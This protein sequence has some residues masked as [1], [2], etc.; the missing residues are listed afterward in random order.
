MC[1]AHWH[2]DPYRLH[3]DKRTVYYLRLLS[4]VDLNRLNS[5]KVKEQTKI[6]LRKALDTIYEH[7]VG[8]YVPAKQFLD[9]MSS[10]DQ[11]LKTDKKN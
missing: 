2:L 7:Q 4:V 8:I 10:W 5:I 1:Q 3:L 9:Q 11:T 6:N